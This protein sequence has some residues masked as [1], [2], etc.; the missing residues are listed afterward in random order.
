MCGGTYAVAATATADATIVR[1]S[2]NIM[3]Y[4]SDS[5]GEE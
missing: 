4:F 5:V 3:I 2:L 1:N